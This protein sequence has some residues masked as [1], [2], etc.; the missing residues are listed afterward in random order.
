M[1]RHKV[2]SGLLN[3]ELNTVRMIIG[4]T[5]NNLGGLRQ[6]FKKGD[7]FDGDSYRKTGM[8]GQSRSS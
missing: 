6:F 5:G 1:F 7:P 2:A 3:T 4:L 8:A